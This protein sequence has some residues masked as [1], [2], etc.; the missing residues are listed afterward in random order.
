M[1]LNEGLK[2]VGKL[3]KNTRLVFQAA[4]FIEDSAGNI[5]ATATATYVKMTAARIAGKPLTADQWFFLPDE[6]REIEIVNA[7]YFDH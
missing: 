7:D 2:V 6:E 1:P 4:G 5:L 3:T